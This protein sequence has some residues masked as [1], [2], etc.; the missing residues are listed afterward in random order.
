MRIFFPLG[1]V[2]ALVALA[3]AVAQEG[4]ETGKAADCAVET[5]PMLQLSPD[6]FDQ[7]MTGGWRNL[8]SRDGC[9][10]AAAD[11]IRT[12]IDHNWGRIPQKN[13]H[14]MY[15]HAGQ[16]EALAGDYQKAI[17]LLMA[18]V[19]P[20]ARGREMGFHDYAQGTIAFLNRDL[21]GLKAARQR[22]SVLPE[23]AWFKTEFKDSS[24]ITW[25]ANLSILDSLI[26]CFESP[27]AVAYAG[28]CP[29][30]DKEPPP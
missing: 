21:A 20:T 24:S 17:P 10:K 25:P 28:I 27:Y 8:A 1:V 2:L 12:Y 4:R 5:G 30:T 26:R 29:E 13:L 14:A 15:W 7:D 11:L 9:A 3:P 23:P 18:G 16:M 6:A 19:S 22:L